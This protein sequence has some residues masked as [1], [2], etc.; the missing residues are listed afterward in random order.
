MQFEGAVFMI[1]PLACKTWPSTCELC[2]AIC[3]RM[4]KA[5]E[6]S[7]INAIASFLVRS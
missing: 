5:V 4:S 7:G 1:I 6:L 2:A 3:A